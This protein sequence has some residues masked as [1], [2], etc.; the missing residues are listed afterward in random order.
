MSFMGIVTRQMELNAAHMQKIFGM[1]D[2]FV[3]KIEKEFQVQIIDRNG[4]L[5]ITGE[6][7]NA[8]RVCHIISQLNTISHRGNEI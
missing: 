6:E 7:I 8:D 1:Q 5:Q 3:K 4:M 2:A